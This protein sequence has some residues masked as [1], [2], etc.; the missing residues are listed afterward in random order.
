M[1]SHVG[2]PFSLGL[3][4]AFTLLADTPPSATA[5]SGQSDSREH[6]TAIPATAIDTDGT[7]SI[8]S[9]PTRNGEGPRCLEC[10]SNP[11]VTLPQL[12]AILQ[13]GREMSSD[14]VSDVFEAAWKI[15]E[16]ERAKV[17]RQRAVLLEDAHK[18]SL[19][20]GEKMCHASA[21]GKEQRGDTVTMTAEEENGQHN[22]GRGHTDGGEGL[23]ATEGGGPQSGPTLE[24][25]LESVPNGQATALGS[26]GV[27]NPEAANTDVTGSEAEELGPGIVD[28]GQD[29]GQR[30]SCSPKDIIKDGSLSVATTSQAPRKV[31]FAAVSECDAVRLWIRRGAYMLPSFEVTSGSS[32]LL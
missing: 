15:D 10:D 2:I 14:I 9:K 11:Y 13:Y 32:F 19:L 21:V 17:R 31:S 7:R 18:G 12:H 26:M 20:N 3:F 6:T 8:T 28:D 27:P 4:R 5:G 16:D 23:R 25:Q 1:V 29:D 30:P 22:D 24:A